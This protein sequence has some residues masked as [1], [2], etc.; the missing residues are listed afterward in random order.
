MTKMNMSKAINHA[1][2][3]EMHRDEKVLVYGE[4]L[5]VAGGSWRVAENLQK[6][7]GVTRVFDTPLAESAIAGMAVGLGYV[8][9]RSV[10]EI[11]YSG[12]MFEAMDALAG[13]M[14]RVHYRSGGAFNAPIT[15]RVPFGSGMGVVELHNDNLEGLLA[16][17]HGLKVVMPSSPYD[18]KGLMISAIRDNNPVI[19]F[20]HL[21]LYFNTEEDVPEEEYMIEI[22]KASIKKE[23]HDVTLITYG[24]MVEK[25]MNVS[26]TIADKGIKAEVIDLRSLSPIDYD[27]LITSIQK[28]KRAIIIQEAQRSA[29]VANIISSKLNEELFTELKSPISVIASPDTLHPFVEVEDVWVSNENMIVDKISSLFENQK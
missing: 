9:Y 10:I 23:G 17:S 26:K 25:V 12:F 28:T 13:Q 1:I 18:A 8:G 22:D 16:Q 15:V 24:A 5:G 6:E 27:T 29:G 4:D 20:E 19:F 7:F 21:S 2:R 14:A 3:N 11:E